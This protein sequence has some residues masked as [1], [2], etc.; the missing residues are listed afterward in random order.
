MDTIT[1]NFKINGEAVSASVPTK[2]SLLDYLDEKRLSPTITNRLS[3]MKFLRDDLHLTGTKN[4]CGTNHCGNCMVLVNGVAKKSCLLQMKSLQNAEI[5][6]V[7]GLTPDSNGSLHPIQAAFIDAGGSQCGFVTRA[8]SREAASCA[9]SAVIT[10]DSI[11]VS[12]TLL[13]MSSARS[14]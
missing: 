1:V 7:E 2:D 10:P 6:T 3:L 11:S 13:R 5:I 9:C 14:G 8:R 12:S 4:G